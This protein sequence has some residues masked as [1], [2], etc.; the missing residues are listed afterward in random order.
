MVV[1]PTNKDPQSYGFLPSMVNK[2]DD[3]WVI[4]TRH[5]SDEKRSSKISLLAQSIQEHCVNG[6]LMYLVLYCSIRDDMR[7]LRI[8][9][10]Y[11]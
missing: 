6:L 4:L 10:K 8:V 7:G 3:N 2:V 11:N 5:C 9:F 1:T